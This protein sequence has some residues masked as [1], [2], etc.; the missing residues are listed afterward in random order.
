[1]R[2]SR[3][4]IAVLS[5]SAEPQCECD[6]WG[7]LRHRWHVQDPQPQESVPAGTPK[8]ELSEATGVPE[9]AQ[10]PS[11]AGKSPQGVP[12]AGV[13]PVDG[14]GDEQPRKRASRA[15]KNAAMAS[16]KA[17]RMLEED[18][19]DEGSMED[20]R[21]GRRSSKKVRAGRVDIPLSLGR[22]FVVTPGPMPCTFCL[23]SCFPWF[24][25]CGVHQFIV[26]V[27]RALL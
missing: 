17:N 19:E 21:P 2:T 7:V 20:D 4:R 25:M 23:T 12:P 14:G 5:F 9:Q 16:W 15:S 8:V 3:V 22:L 24:C 1:M 10:S 11:T 13:S 18:G 27:G 6:R 26:L